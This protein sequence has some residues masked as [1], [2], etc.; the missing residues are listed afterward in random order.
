MNC[1]IKDSIR[2]SAVTAMQ[3]DEVKKLLGR[4]EVEIRERTKAHLI[5]QLAATICFTLHHHYGFGR[6]RLAKF[7]RLW[8]ED[9]Q[10]LMDP[11]LGE[12]IVCAEEII[13]WCSEKFGIDFNDVSDVKLDKH[14]KIVDMDK[15]I[16]ER[17][18]AKKRRK[19]NGR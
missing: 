8:A 7:F 11:P 12:G 9:M 19:K 15:V 16:A 17:V 14:G 18:E 10:L 13:P 6:K 3:S 5:P 2:R 4:A 1:N